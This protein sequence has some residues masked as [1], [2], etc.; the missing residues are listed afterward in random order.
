MARKPSSRARKPGDIRHAIGHAWSLRFQ[1]KNAQA[2]EVLEVIESWIASGSATATQEDVWQASLIKASLLRSRGLLSKSNKILDELSVEI[3]A[4][5]SR[6]PFNYYFQKA[7]N[8]FASDDFAV[9]LEFFLLAHSVTVDVS[10]Q[11]LCLMNIL[12]CLEN[13]GLPLDSTL[14]EM[15]T[16]LKKKTAKN[17]HEPVR[18]QLNAFRLRDLFRNGRIAEIFSTRLSEN[19]DQ[20]HYYRLWVSR[21]PF[22]EPGSRFSSTLALEQIARAADLHAK[23]YRLKTVMADPRI[24]E[25]LGS[26]QA[27]QTAQQ[28]DRIYLWTWFWLTHPSEVNRLLLKEI[29]TSFDFRSALKKMTFED[30]QMLQNALS[31]IALFQKRLAPEIED[32]LGHFSVQNF[33]PLPLFHFESLCIRYLQA[34]SRGQAGTEELRQMTKHPF[35]NSQN[36]KLREMT[37]N[38]RGQIQNPGLSIPV[39]SKA[40]LLDEETHRIFKG[41]QVIVSESLC[42]VMGALSDLRVMKF[43]EIL[44]IGFGIAPYDSGVHQAKIYNLVA[45]IKGILPKSVHLKGKNEMIYWQGP[46]EAIV[47]LEQPALSKRL[48]EH[49]SDLRL[50]AAGASLERRVFSRPL[51]PRAVVQKAGGRQALQREEFQELMSLSKASANRWLNKWIEQGLIRP[52]G[53]GRSTIYH[54]EIN[55]N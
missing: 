54:I 38:L 25:P 28:V 30:F 20:S 43:S 32:Y 51:H 29:L 45:R 41:R 50:Q 11:L 44:W 21:L 55:R 19:V 22:V 4:K 2:Q 23:S 35:S 52:Q 18:A 53:K 49:N 34:L 37:E 47:K 39:N 33:E 27:V 26:D 42:K 36:L 10:E 15:E 3:F 12:T 7:L 14:A 9:A 24:Q 17:G 6:A 5:S 8:V 1:Q 13:L 48:F 46:S 16:L 31:W 40:V